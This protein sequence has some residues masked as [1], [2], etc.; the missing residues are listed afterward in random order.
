MTSSSGIISSPRWPDKF[1]MNDLPWNGYCSWNVVG[2][3]YEKV[4]V[5]VMDF[6]FSKSNVYT[7]KC[8]PNIVDSKLYIGNSQI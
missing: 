8:L 4:Q 5:N 6:Q 1:S 3:K 2:E 7:T